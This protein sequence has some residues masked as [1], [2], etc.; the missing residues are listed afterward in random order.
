MNHILTRVLMPF[1]RTDSLDPTRLNIHDGT[2][3]ELWIAIYNQI[4][5]GCSRL[6]CPRVLLDCQMGR[7]SHQRRRPGK[8]DMYNTQMDI[9][10]TGDTRNKHR[11]DGR[12]SRARPAMSIVYSFPARKTGFFSIRVLLKK[13][14]R[15]PLT[16]IPLPV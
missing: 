11:P 1:H 12:E 8:M 9:L 16:R 2:L 5:L 15:L 3:L 13:P 6:F 7:W 4:L 14:A 10:G